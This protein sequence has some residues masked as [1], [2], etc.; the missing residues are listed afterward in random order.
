[1]NEIS[2]IAGPFIPRP[3]KLNKQVTVVKLLIIYFDLYHLD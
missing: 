1:M 2:Y 3:D